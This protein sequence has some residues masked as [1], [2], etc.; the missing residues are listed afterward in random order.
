MSFTR[1]FI[2][3]KT[4]YNYVFTLFLFLHK[5]NLMSAKLYLYFILKKINIMV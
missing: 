3:I 4:P 1:I 2:E 5:L